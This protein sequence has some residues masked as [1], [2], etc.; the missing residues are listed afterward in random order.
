MLWYITLALSPTVDVAG[1]RFRGLVRC[2]CGTLEL[3]LVS[4]R[5]STADGRRVLRP[6]NPH[7]ETSEYSGIQHAE[8][9]AIVL[10]LA[11]AGTVKTATRGHVICVDDVSI[12]FAVRSCQHCAK[13]DNFLKSSR[14]M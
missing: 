9:R 11:F 4:S 2:S 3:V 6:P 7:R 10:I 14:S 12:V 1:G 8:C 13:G 5:P